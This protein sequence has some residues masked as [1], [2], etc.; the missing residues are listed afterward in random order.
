MGHPLHAHARGF[1]A[2]HGAVGEQHGVEL[3]LVAA[4]LRSGAMVLLVRVVPRIHR[5][6]LLLRLHLPQVFPVV[7]R[8]TDDGVGM[9]RKVGVPARRAP[10]GAHQI[11]LGGRAL[12]L[13]GSV[14]PAPVNPAR[15]ISGLVSLAPRV[16]PSFAVQGG[17]TGGAHAKVCTDGAVLP[18]GPGAEGLEHLALLSAHVPDLILS[19]RSQGL[20]LARGQ[21]ARALRG[22]EVPQLIFQAELFADGRVR[23]LLL[24]AP[25]L[26]W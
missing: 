20:V 14:V 11:E 4:E 23:V 5:C 2:L 25:P 13:T 6:S 8:R 12:V 7:P 21:E 10:P 9:L 22:A 3:L 1:V 24:R 16:G 15:A 18:L 26:H 17:A 19:R